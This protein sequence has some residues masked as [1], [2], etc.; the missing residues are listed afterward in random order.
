MPVKNPLPLMAKID[1][2]I[3][4]AVPKTRECTIA[5]AE[6]R[7]PTGN[8]AREKI[9]LSRLDEAVELLLG[10]LADDVLCPT[11]HKILH[12]RALVTQLRRQLDVRQPA[13]LE[14]SGQGLRPVLPL[15]GSL[16]RPQQAT[17]RPTSLPPEHV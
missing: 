5:G 17:V 2:E 15:G 4:C 8:D 7:F 12:L 3:L 13:E 9:R 6:V 16:S 1:R 14:P 10:L 11:N